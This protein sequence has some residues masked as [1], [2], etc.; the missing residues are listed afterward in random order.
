VPK[1]AE[2]EVAKITERE[3]VIML[4]E[5]YLGR[6]LD[7]DSLAKRKDLAVIIAKAKTYELIAAPKRFKDVALNSKEAKYIDAC[8]RNK[9]M[10]GYEDGTFRPENDL[11]LAS[12]ISTMSD[13][14]SDKETRVLMWQYLG[15]LN[16]DKPASF[17]EVADAIVASSYL[18]SNYDLVVP[19]GIVIV[20][21]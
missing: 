1:V 19:A 3:V 10:S 18:K 7:L 9:S 12:L 17:N 2:P 21:Q 11:S 16:K 4:L 13:S 6:Q 5:K 20:Y 14:E 15:K 8:Y